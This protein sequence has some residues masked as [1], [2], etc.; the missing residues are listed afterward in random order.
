MRQHNQNPGASP[1]VSFS[2]FD[3]QFP[4]LALDNVITYLQTVDPPAAK[5]A[6]SLFAPFRPYQD[7]SEGY[8]K[9]SIWIQGMCHLNLQ[10]VYQLLFQHRA[11]YIGKSS[12]QQY[13]YALQSARVAIQGET[14]FSYS[15]ST[16]IR[17]GF[18]AENAQ[19]LL[20]QGGQD[21]KIVLWAHNLHVRTPGLNSTVVMG[22]ILRSVYPEDLV[23]FGFAFYRGS[24]NAV[25]QNGSVYGVLGSVNADIPPADSYEY[26]FRAAG[27]SRFI[28]DMRPFVGTAAWINGP[29]KQREVGSSY[30][31]Q[32]PGDYYYT[33]S[34]PR[35]FDV[36]IY[37]QDSSP[38]TLLPF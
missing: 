9:S 1:K 32:K 27:M 34:L 23:T 12:E 28:L 15:F 13:A 26:G 16:S 38:S 24:F 10:L 7:S 20:N 11:E 33:M 21:A 37:F 17:D 25:A 30:D 3:M 4:H 6:D 29:W 35:T 2:G 5:T 14:Y 22:D 31:P 19:W 8:A 36:M 18:M